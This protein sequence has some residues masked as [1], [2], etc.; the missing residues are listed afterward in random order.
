[1]TQNRLTE[2]NP[3]SVILKFTLP[4][5]LG[6]VFQQLYNMAD[7]IIV[8]R[9]VGQNALAAVGSTGTIMFLVLGIAIGLTTGYTVMT[10]QR[11]GAGDVHGTRRSTGNAIVL[12][13]ITAVVITVL[14]VSLLHPILRIMNTPAEIYEDAYAYISVICLGTICSVFYN[15][16]AAMLRSVG[17]SKMPLVFLVLSAG[18]N[19]ILDLIC[20]IAF[21]MG[22]RGA[23]VAT[24]TA[25]GISAVFAGLYIWKKI[26]D[27]KPYRDI[28]NL[29]KQ[30]ARN[31]LSV[32]IPMA[33]QFGITAS[34]TMIMQAAVNLFGATA[35]AAYTAANKVCSLLNQGFVSLGQTMASYT[36]QNYGKR[37]IGRIR[38]GIRAA[39]KADIIYAIAAGVI[40][41]I[42]LRPLMGLFFSGDTDIAELMPYAWP[43]IIACVICYIPLGFIF[44]FRNTMQGCGYGFLPMVGGVI[45]LLC[46]LVMAAAAIATMYYPLAAWCDASAWL[47][48]GI[49]TLFA[50][51]YIIKKVEQDFLKE[52]ENRL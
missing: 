45:E 39:V 5:F 50:C 32:G 37:D 13:L 34:G 4:L 24:V 49:F 31:Q 44:I 16:F 36:G 52:Q 30:M 26:P 40:C 25:Q 35:V 20:I 8:G 22:T 29:D 7:T 17:N 48:T 9:F 46:R 11:F 6:N 43:Y 18:L 10:A 2:G 19:V 33:L 15:L 21:Q 23:G 42:L 41:V 47:G 1:M 28:W 38:E 3:M 27:V 14:S 12:S 51:R